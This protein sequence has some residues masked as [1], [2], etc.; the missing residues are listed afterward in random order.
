M[1]L[2][3][4]GK[5]KAHLQTEGYESTGVTGPGVQGPHSS[6]DNSS[7]QEH[8]TDQSPTREGSGNG[9]GQGEEAVGR[10]PRGQEPQRW[11]EGSV[12]G[13]SVRPGEPKR[14]R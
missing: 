6:G 1:G 7:A 9:P 4:V 11:D 8:S 13:S 12:S 10:G 14:Q 2:G 5:T 3:N